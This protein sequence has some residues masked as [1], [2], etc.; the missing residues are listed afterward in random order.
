M[1]HSS[2]LNRQAL[3]LR[4]DP[5]RVIVRPFKPSTEPRHLHPR[6]KTRANEIVDR[7]LSL[8]PN[9]TANQLRDILHNFDGRHRNLLR[10]FEMRADS[11]EDAF[12]PHDE[13]SQQERQ[14]IGAYFM[15]EYSFESA[16]LFNPSIVPHPDQSDIPPG[17]CRLI[18]SLRAVGEGH[19]SS[20]TF[21][22]G[23]ID[24]DGNVTI[25]TP[26]RLAGLPDIHANDGLAPVGCIGLSFKVESDLSE[27]VIFPVT[28]AQSNGIEDARFV[29]FEDS[30]K[31]TYY[32]TYT[33]Y[34][35]SSIRSE[36][37]E[38]QDFRNFS[39]T[40]LR[41]P[42]A[43]NKGMALFPRRINGRYAM[44][45][46]QDSE[47]LFLL[48]SDDL[49][50]WDEGH[51]LMKPE[52]AWQFVQIGNCGSPVE[53]DEG[54]LLF[55]HGVGPMRRYA[56]GVTLLDKHDPSIILSR[57]VEPLLQPEATEREGYVPNVVYSCGAM[58]HGDLIAL[59]Y[60]V[61]DTYSNFTT[62]KISKLLDTM[63]P[64]GHGR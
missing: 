19:I 17:S 24:A 7:V 20:L 39:L 23:V 36:I 10:Q 49:H 6:D 27:R 52:F 47:N 42:A 56:I 11:M 8:D 53:I 43:R 54:W 26:V 44:I 41:G 45:A 9:A 34:S 12:L 46:R 14:L 1:P 30:G 55:T 32:A 21:R 38:T 13:F 16:A 60:A 37:L 5:T 57:T 3:Y 61:S 48:Y 2:L 22:S 51:L 18:I 50:H 62:M 4:P 31:T 63:H 35:G 40:P 59:P 28:E 15:N 58:R 29:A 33:A 25:D 64:P